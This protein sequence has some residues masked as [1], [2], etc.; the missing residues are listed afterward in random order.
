MASYKLT[1]FNLTGLG[2]PIRFLMVYGGMKFED[3]RIELE[4]WPKIKPNALFGQLPILEFEGKQINQSKAI[5]RYLAKKVKLDG[6]T[7]WEDLEI[8]AIVDCINDLRF[9]LA[10][11]FW[12]T[13]EQ[14]KSKRKVTV[15][16]QTLPFYLERF[17]NIAKENEGHLALKRLTW[18][19]IYFVA[20]LDYLSFLTEGD[21]IKNYPHLNS[22]KNNVLNIPKIKEWVAKRPKLL[23]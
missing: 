23:F 6:K 13:D 7:D 4:D 16:D 1:Y 5:C 10:D 11:Y 18:A 12:E 21:I 22:V 2:E 20:I 17:E 14:V 8:D 3:C 19:D 15:F 9:K